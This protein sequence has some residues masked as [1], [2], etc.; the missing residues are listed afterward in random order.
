MCLYWSCVLVEGHSAEL[1][2]TGF[3]VTLSEKT[4]FRVCPPHLQNFLSSL[5]LPSPYFSWLIMNHSDLTS[6]N[7]YPI[8]GFHHDF[9]KAIPLSEQG[10]SCFGVSTYS[11]KHT[12]LNMLKETFWQYAFRPKIQFATLKQLPVRG[13][14]EQIWIVHHVWVN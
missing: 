6:H 10:L 1:E 9:Y 12:K 11:H 8:T 3:R 13:S 4:L 7:R 14:R 2:K 5:F